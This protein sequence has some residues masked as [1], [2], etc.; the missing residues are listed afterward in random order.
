MSRKLLKQIRNEWASNI[1][2]AVELLVVSVVL[3]YILDYFYVTYRVVS[4]PLGYDV[5]H[6]YKLSFSEVTDKNPSYIPDRTNRQTVDDML[7]IL[8]RLQHLPMIEAASLS[9]NSHPY[10]GSNSGSTVWKD[11][12]YSRGYTVRRYVTPD[13]VRVFRYQGARGESP[14]ELARM[15]DEGKV[16]VNNTLFKDYGRDMTEFIGE[17]FCVDDSS[18]V[19][20]L[21]AALVGPRYGDFMTWE[22]TIVMNLITDRWGWALNEVC[23]RV[24]PDMDKDIVETLMGQAESLF[25]VGNQ[26]LV[27]VAPFKDIRRAVIQDD[28]NELM[29]MY[30]GLGFLLL[31]VFLGLFGTFWF[32]TQQR[33]G[34]IA[35]RKALGATGWE[36]LRRLIGEGLLLLLMVTPIAYGFD[37]LLTYLGLS[38]S[39]MDET[40]P[41]VY[42][43]ALG[44]ALAAAGLIALM[45]V[46]GVWFPASRAEKIDPAI[47][48]KDE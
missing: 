32:R 43:Q 21:G 9:S 7:K 22:N 3:W 10:N 25:H 48:L 38:N 35:I 36:V 44:C 33:V 6:C 15:L 11:T 41:V 28:K 14:E 47:A 27:N 8:D 12:L 17:E 37:C 2:L 45:I 24:K 19:K 5:E 29:Y 23:I 18:K 16:L 1:W 31:N 42:L 46:A 40:G 30:V 13:F 39:Y 20:V 26:L 34:E 4:A